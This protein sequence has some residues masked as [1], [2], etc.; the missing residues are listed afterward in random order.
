MA[1]NLDESILSNFGGLAENNLANTVHSSSD[2]E[3]EIS[4]I[5]HSP[6]F[7]DNS[8]L[9]LLQTQHDNF[10][11]LTLNAQSIQAKIDKL[12]IFLDQ[13]KST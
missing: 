10:T 12:V 6:Y 5:K 2:S 13:L 3:Y 11:V 9:E 1:T 8:L 7:D 4:T